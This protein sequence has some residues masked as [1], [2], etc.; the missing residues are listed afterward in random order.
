M[1]LITGAVLLITMLS[2]FLNGISFEK[3]EF[4]TNSYDFSGISEKTVAYGVK[5]E[6]FEILK[7]NDI[8]NAKIT[9]NT[10]TDKNNSIK[11]ND[12]IILFDIRDKDKTKL[13]KRKINKKLKMNVETR[14]EE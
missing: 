12:I 11:V 10:Q 2:P 5:T 9:I 1:R 3:I 14:V 4:N 13:I 7:E 6:I 8:E